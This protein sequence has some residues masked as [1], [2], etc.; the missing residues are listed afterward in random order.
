LTVV[1]VAQ[2]CIYPRNDTLYTL[3]GTEL[4]LNEAVTKNKTT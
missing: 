2:L 1:L 3:N 4:Y